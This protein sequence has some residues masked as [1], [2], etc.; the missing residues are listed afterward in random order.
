MQDRRVK[1]TEYIGFYFKLTFYISPMGA[2]QF[3]D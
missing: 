1:Q 2:A 3:D